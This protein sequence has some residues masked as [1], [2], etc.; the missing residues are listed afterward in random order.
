ML[1]SLRSHPPWAKNIYCKGENNK[2]TITA[3][4]PGFPRQGSANP[5]GGTP[6]YYVAKFPPKL[7][8]NEENYTERGWASNNLLCR[9]ATCQIARSQSYLQ[10]FSVNGPLGQPIL[11]IFLKYKINVS[12]HLLFF[13][14]TFKSPFTCEKY[15]RNASRFVHCSGGSTGGHP[16]AAPLRPKMFSISC[17]IFGNLAKFVCWRAP[18]E[19]RRPFLRRIL[20]PTLH[21]V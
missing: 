16:G 19:G 17:I 1:K 18:P 3:A 21:Y 6:T 9:S 5:K 10:S 20:D 14:I 13:K 4:D 8:G 12:F 7:H 15:Q 2:I 11:Q